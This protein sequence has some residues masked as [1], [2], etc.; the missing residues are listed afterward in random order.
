MFQFLSFQIFC[1]L[2]TPL[3][4]ILVS[5]YN[6]LYLVHHSCAFVKIIIW[7]IYR[8]L[9]P[10]L[11]LFITILWHCISFLSSCIRFLCPCITSL[12]LVYQNF[13]LASH[14]CPFAYNNWSWGQYSIQITK[15]Q[16]VQWEDNIP[17]ARIFPHTLSQ[18][19]EKRATMQRN[20]IWAQTNK[21]IIKQT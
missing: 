18:G 3:Y 11:G 9:M 20:N 5:L 6:F 14:L 10:F 17:V 1:S 13:P 8:P 15:P 4:A 12:H 19:L 2:P 16:D 7:G 21:R